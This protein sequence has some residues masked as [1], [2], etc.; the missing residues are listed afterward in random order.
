MALLSL[1]RVKAWMSTSI[2]W[3]RLWIVLLSIFI[4][5]FSS[6][7]LS[8][9]LRSWFCHTLLSITQKPVATGIS[10]NLPLKLDWATSKIKILQMYASTIEMNKFSTILSCAL[11]LVSDGSSVVSNICWNY[12]MP[13]LMCSNIAAKWSELDMS[14]SVKRN[15]ICCIYIFS[16]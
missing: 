8:F 7:V 4:S 5:V 16:S 15:I 14:D 1:N 12:L 13:T 9:F 10:L 6:F 11:S 3:F 2:I